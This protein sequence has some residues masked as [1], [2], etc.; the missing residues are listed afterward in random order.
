MSRP[1][2]GF[3][4]RRR[5]PRRYHTGTGGGWSWSWK[6]YPIDVERPAVLHDSSTSGVGLLV[7]KE[8]A[9]NPG[10]EFDLRC[11]ETGRRM[12]CRVVSA[13]SWQKGQMTL[14]GCRIQP[15]RRCSAI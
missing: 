1:E 3:K 12:H 8:F 6:Q 7:R 15:D 2:K 14:V 10:Q 4:E 9:P 11:N 13:Q 5:Q